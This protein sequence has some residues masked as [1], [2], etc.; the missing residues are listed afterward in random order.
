MKR[1][2]SCPGFH[3]CFCF[4]YDPKQVTS[5]SPSFGFFSLKIATDKTYHMESCFANCKTSY[6]YKLLSLCVSVGL[7]LEPQL[8]KTF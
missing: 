2:A 5:L 4:L 8:R 3:T 7:N 1:D 6:K